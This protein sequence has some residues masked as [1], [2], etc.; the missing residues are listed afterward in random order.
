MPTIK[1]LFF[2][3][4]VTLSV[5]AENIKPSSFDKNGD[6]FE[7][8]YNRSKTYA[9]LISQSD[10]AQKNKKELATLF[11]K[12]G[13]YNLKLPKMKYLKTADGL[14]MTID[15]GGLELKRNDLSIWIDSKR[16][17][18]ILSDTPESIYERM[19]KLASK[20]TV[21]NSIFDLFLPK[22]N[23]NPELLLGI[24][25]GAI[26]NIYFFWD[27]IRDHYFYDG[28]KSLAKDVS[29]LE[30]ERIAVALDHNANEK[31]VNYA[32]KSVSYENHRTILPLG[33]SSAKGSVKPII[34]EFKGDRPA[35]FTYGRKGEVIGIKTR[36]GCEVKLNQLGNFERTPE[37]NNSECKQF[38]GPAKDVMFNLE[39]YHLFSRLKEQ[40]EKGKLDLEKYKNARA[41]V[42][43]ERG[44]GDS[45]HGTEN[46][47]PQGIR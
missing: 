14:R 7:F 38:L 10:I 6:K 21:F 24:I 15:S 45:L 17:T 47:N 34:E 30:C 9:D 18:I 5:H 4:L 29:K 19:E 12:K 40:C 35:S 39:G 32:P 11:S 28:A 16:L 31:K 37:S 26:I 3:I 25:G 2:L 1:L 46:A 43:S 36:D 8:L 41:E 22:A 23:A 20:K 44:S 42:L 33:N 27:E 13:L